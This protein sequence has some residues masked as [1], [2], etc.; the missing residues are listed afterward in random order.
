MQILFASANIPS[1]ARGNSVCFYLVMEI[2][3]AR[4]FPYGYFLTKLRHIRNNLSD[5]E[6]GL[7]TF[8]AT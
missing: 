2:L 8:F 5:D 4:V 7:V 1:T 6:Q 3:S